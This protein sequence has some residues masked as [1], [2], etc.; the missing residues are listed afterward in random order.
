MQL[1][2]RRL[3]ICTMANSSNHIYKYMCE[4]YVSKKRILSLVWKIAREGLGGGYIL[5]RQ[6]RWKMYCIYELKQASE[7]VLLCVAVKYG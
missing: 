7:C 2:L 3:K 4:F 6:D 1:G 5:A